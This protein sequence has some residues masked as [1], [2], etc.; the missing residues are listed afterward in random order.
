[1]FIWNCIIINS[2]LLRVICKEVAKAMIIC[3]NSNEGNML[4]SG[5]RH[6][7]TSSLVFTTDLTHYVAYEVDTLFI[8]IIFSLE[9][10]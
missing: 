3:C 9:L 5:E 4:L 8:M 10:L 2:I 7:F 6:G 1:M